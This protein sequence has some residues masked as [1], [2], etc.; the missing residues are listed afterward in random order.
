MTNDIN[1]IDLNEFC[2]GL[3]QVLIV[4]DNEENRIK[5]QY[6]NSINW[7][8]IIQKIYKN[9]VVLSEYNFCDYTD[10]KGKYVSYFYFLD[11]EKITRIKYF[12]RENENKNVDIICPAELKLNLQKE[13][14]RANF[15]VANL[16]E[17]IDKERIY[18][19]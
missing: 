8:E 12:L 17:Y 7:N 1:R 18:Y 2:F 19:D 3:N 15:I 13:L 4:K 9:K 5:L 10:Y 14:P 6:V 11:T 16:E